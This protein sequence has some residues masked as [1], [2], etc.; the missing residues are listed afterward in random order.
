MNA[1]DPDALMRD[2]IEAHGGEAV[3]VARENARRAAVSG[4]L[5]QAKLWL[6]VVGLIQRARPSNIPI[7]AADHG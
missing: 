4:Q 7:K 3:I 6:R 2:M 5:D 1:P